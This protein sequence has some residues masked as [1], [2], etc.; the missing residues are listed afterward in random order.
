MIKEADSKVIVIHG[1]IGGALK[2]LSY[3]QTS[4]QLLKSLNV[5]QVYKSNILSRTSS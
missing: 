4:Q 2:N 5:V 1:L 3:C